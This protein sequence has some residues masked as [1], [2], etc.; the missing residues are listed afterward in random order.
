MDLVSITARIPAVGETV[1]GTDFQ[2][3]TGGKGANQ[4][5]AV[6]WA[7]TPLASN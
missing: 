5:V 2:I 6:T 1:V 7:Q 3:H 4:A